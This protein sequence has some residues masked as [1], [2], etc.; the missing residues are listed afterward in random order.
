MGRTFRWWFGRHGTTS[1]G[2]RKAPPDE[3]GNGVVLREL[4]HALLDLGSSS[5][6][7]LQATLFTEQPLGFPEQG[8]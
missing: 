1:I 5:C 8:A 4:D 6:S 3:V 7:V 2:T